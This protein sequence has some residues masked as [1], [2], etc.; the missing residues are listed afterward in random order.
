MAGLRCCGK[1]PTTLI[2]DHPIKHRQSGRI[3]IYIVSYSSIQLS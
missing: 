1:L 2:V 3:L